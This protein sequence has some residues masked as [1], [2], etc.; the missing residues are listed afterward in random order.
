VAAVFDRAELA[1]ALGLHS[2]FA[3]DDGEEA[4]KE[5]L[6]QPRPQLLAGLAHSSSGSSEPASLM[7]DCAN[8]QGIRL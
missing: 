2:P 4:D 5:H 6:S 1:L 3:I 7:T 8:D